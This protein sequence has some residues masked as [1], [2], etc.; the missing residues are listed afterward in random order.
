MNKVNVLE[1]RNI[2]NNVRNQLTEKR[3]IKLS[4]LK[5]PKNSPI[6]KSEQETKEKELQEAIKNNAWEKAVELIDKIPNVNHLFFIN[7]G[8]HF[9]SIKE[10]EKAQDYYIKGMQPMLA[11][12]MYIKL[13]EETFQKFGDGNTPNNRKEDINTVINKYKPFFE[14]IENKIKQLPENKRRLNEEEKKNIINKMNNFKIS[15]FNLVNIIKSEK[16]EKQLAKE[17]NE[18]IKKVFDEQITNKGNN[19]NELKDEDIFIF[20]ENSNSIEEIENILNL[21]KN[22]CHLLYLIQTKFEHISKIYLG[23]NTS[24]N[25]DKIKGIETNS[26]QKVKEIHES[27]LKKEKEKKNY[28]IKFENIIKKHIEY[29]NDQDIFNLL[30]LKEMIMNHKKNGNE[31]KGLNEMVNQTIKKTLL[32]LASWKRI[33]SRQIVDLILNVDNHFLLIHIYLLK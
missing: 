19:N 15:L 1:K 23:R 5:I 31:L 3:D 26:L 13:S 32:N 29:F 17:K 22:L 25:I 21:S 6:Q 28:F 12:N 20:I 24:L 9:E 14:D 18:T 2:N 10:Y 4:K 30:L 16:E 27:I 7:I 11:F 8:R 33:N